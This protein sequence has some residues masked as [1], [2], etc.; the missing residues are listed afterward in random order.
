ME[1]Q[2]NVEMASPV[3]QK[4]VDQLYLWTDNPAVVGY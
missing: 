2:K 3:E 4:A 1:K